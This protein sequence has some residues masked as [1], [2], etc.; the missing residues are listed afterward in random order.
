MEVETAGTEVVVVAVVVD[1]LSM[2]LS[3]RSKEASI[4]VEIFFQVSSVSLLLSS[5]TFFKLANHK[6]KTATTITIILILNIKAFL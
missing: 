5:K 6:K 4:S 3:R 1:K 2:A